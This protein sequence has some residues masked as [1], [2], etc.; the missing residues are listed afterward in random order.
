MRWVV[1]AVFACGCFTRQTVA[2]P[3]TSVYIEPTPGKME[4]AG[5]MKNIITTKCDKPNLYYVSKEY[6]DDLWFWCEE[7]E[8]EFFDECGCGCK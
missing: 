5:I 7:D 4:D 3:I 6:C 2:P 1:I 8:E